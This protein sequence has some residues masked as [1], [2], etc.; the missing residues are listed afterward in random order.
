MTPPYDCGG[1]TGVLAAKTIQE[2]LLALEASR[3][4]RRA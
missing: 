4:H 3:R 1:I 2:V